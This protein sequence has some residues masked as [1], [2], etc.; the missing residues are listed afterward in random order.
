MSKYCNLC[1]ANLANGT[2][3]C[4]SCGRDLKNMPIKH[5]DLNADGSIGRKAEKC[6]LCGAIH[7]EY[8]QCMRD[9]EED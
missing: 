1:N 7:T 3:V 6:K 4:P 9:K 2:L 5:W 8:Q